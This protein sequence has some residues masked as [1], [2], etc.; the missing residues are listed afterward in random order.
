LSDL[1][2]VI[3]MPPKTNI[4]CF[5]RPSM[6]YVPVP[7]I[8]MR[9]L[10][11]FSVRLASRRTHT[12]RASTLVLCATLAIH[13]LLL[14]MFHYRWVSMLMTLFISRRILRWNHFSSVYYGS[15]SNLILWV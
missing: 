9:E 2:R 4:G 13:R 12:T 15:V 7:V 8:G 10:I 11:P 1:L 5:K 6:D 14:H 3:R